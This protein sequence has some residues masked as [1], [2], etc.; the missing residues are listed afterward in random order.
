MS[1]RIISQVQFLTQRRQ[2]SITRPSNTTQYAAGD[3]ISAVTTNDHLTFQNCANIGRY[4]GTIDAA[5]CFSSANQT[6]K[7]DL[8][9]WLFHTDI[10]KVADNNAFAPTDA[11]MLT[12]IG[13]ID[14]DSWR[15]GLSGSGTDGNIV[16]EVRNIGLPFV[17]AGLADTPHIY[18]QLVERGTYTPISAEVF[19]VELSLYLD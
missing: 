13:V 6:T 5:R 18:G 3:V 10:A 15:V 12:L 2:A 14:F 19:T 17:I 7:P 16:S 9:L 1:S 8:E 11:E 4:T